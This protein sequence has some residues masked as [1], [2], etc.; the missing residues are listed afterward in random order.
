M[1]RDQYS[2]AEGTGIPRDRAMA[3]ETED[4]IFTVSVLPCL[5]QSLKGTKL[6]GV[7]ATSWPQKSG[8]WV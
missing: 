7:G 8:K 3:L 2:D 1:S 6:G 4:S 5:L